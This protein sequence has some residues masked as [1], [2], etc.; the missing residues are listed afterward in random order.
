MIAT[1][2]TIDRAALTNPDAAEQAFAEGGISGA[3]LKPRSLAVLRRLHAR[4]RGT[5]D[6]GRR[7]RHRDG[8][9]RMGARPRRRDAAAG[10]TGFVYGGPLFAAHLGHDLAALARAQGYARVQDAVGAGAPSPA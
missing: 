7:R 6:A 2:T 10:Y 1:N 8:R 3:P 5:A 4:T 9:E